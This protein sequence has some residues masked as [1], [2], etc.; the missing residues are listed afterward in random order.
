[1]VGVVDNDAYNGTI[2]K[3]SFNFKHNSINFITI[4]RGGVSI[5]QKHCNLILQTT[6]SFAVIC[7]CLLK[8]VNIIA[9]LAMLFHES[10]TRM[11]VPYLLLIRHHSWI[12]P[13]SDLD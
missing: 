5:L 6:A 13:R 9:T 8:L 3:S 1:M 4:Y 7:V 12:Q 2:Q 11:V 10:N